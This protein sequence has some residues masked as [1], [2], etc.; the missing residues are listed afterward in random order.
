MEIDEILIE[1]QEE[2]EKQWPSGL[3]LETSV[4]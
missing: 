3:L 4:C 1:A 2:V